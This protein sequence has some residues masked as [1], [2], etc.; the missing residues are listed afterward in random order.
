MDIPQKITPSVQGQ[1]QI[2]TPKADTI[3]PSKTITFKPSVTN[4]EKITYKTTEIYSVPPQN[5]GT[6]PPV[7]TQVQVTQPPGSTPLPPSETV[8]QTITTVPPVVPPVPPTTPPSEVSPPFLPDFFGGG[9]GGDIAPVP[10]DDSGAFGFWVGVTPFLGGFSGGE[11]SK[12]D[13]K[14]ESPLDKLI[15]DYIIWLLKQGFPLD[16]AQKIAIKVI[17]EMLKKKQLVV[18]EAKHKASISR[19]VNPNVP[20][21]KQSIVRA[22]PVKDM[23]LIKMRG[24]LL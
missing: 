1:Y 11:S 23:A 12:K 7:E 18:K 6:T 21:K 13:E 22:R 10:I 2:V 20:L 19:K 16:V 15:E 9:G 17:S 5:Q 4:S 14:K 3:T 8:T 24:S